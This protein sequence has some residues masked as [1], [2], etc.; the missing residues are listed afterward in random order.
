MVTFRRHSLRG[1]ITTGGNAASVQTTKAYDDNVWALTSAEIDSIRT[2]N[3]T[4]VPDAVL[5]LPL[6]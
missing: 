5:D 2:T 3:S 4:S 6:G 1:L